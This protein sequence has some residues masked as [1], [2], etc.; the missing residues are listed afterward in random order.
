MA[1]CFFCST[2]N[3]D[4]NTA[5]LCGKKCGISVCMPEALVS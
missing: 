2:E 5:M 3:D 1:S 4:H